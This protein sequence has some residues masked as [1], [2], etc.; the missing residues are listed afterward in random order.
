MALNLSSK[1]LQIDKANVQIVTA[2]AVAVFF[3]IFALIGTKAMV[4]QLQYQSKLIS[5]KQ[6]AKDTL[7]EN[8]KNTEKLV[9]AYQ[10]F[11]AEPANAIG[12]NT[13]G[14]G[15]RDGNNARIVL[16]ALPS[17]YDYPALAT[18]VQKMLTQPG[19]TIDSITGIDDEVNQ[20]ANQ[21]NA[22]PQPVDMPFEATVSTNYATLLNILL[23]LE[24]SIRPI[25]M[26]S[27]SITAADKS[28]KLTIKANT[29]YQPEKILEIKKEV[30]K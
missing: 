23:T 18:S 12:G 19:S 14:E 26:Q 29:Y 3:A 21:K 11:I 6:L 8:I 15:D 16:D 7:D 5:K 28:I 9:N 25:Q 30:V 4:A 10:A 13:T 20:A 24:H 22:H 27:L 2:V 1:Q 17:K